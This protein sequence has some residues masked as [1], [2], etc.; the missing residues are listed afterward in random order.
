METEKIMKE[1]DLGG[2]CLSGKK[3]V[4]FHGW[5]GGSVFGRIS[6]PGIWYN[7]L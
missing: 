7:T 4:C 1:N 2:L 5:E 3:S 6:C